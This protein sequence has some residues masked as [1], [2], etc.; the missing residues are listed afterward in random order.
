M[1]NFRLTP[2]FFFERIIFLIGCVIRYVIVALNI[3]GR[4]SFPSYLHKKYAFW[5]FLSKTAKIKGMYS[6]NG[7]RRIFSLC[8]YS[9]RL[10]VQI[11][12]RFYINVKASAERVSLNSVQQF[13]VVF[14]LKSSQMCDVTKARKFELL[15]Y[16]N[17]DS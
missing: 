3:Q 5:L 1:L 16:W 4:Q 15:I 17:M 8:P 12:A 6:Q 14:V 13:V 9:N 10:V 11:F 7:L 2:F